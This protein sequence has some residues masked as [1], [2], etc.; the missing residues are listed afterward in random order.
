ME[1][2]GRAAM[3]FWKFWLEVVSLLLDFPNALF[4]LLRW[5]LN[6]NGTIGAQNYTN[7]IPN[8][9]IPVDGL[10]FIDLVSLAMTTPGYTQIRVRK[11]AVPRTIKYHP[12]GASQQL[13]NIEPFWT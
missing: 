8:N 1:F 10:V 12:F 7:I 6:A 4:V 2:F 11:Y 9:K 13:Q 5:N 3:C